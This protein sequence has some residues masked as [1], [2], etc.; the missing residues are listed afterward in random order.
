M[1]MLHVHSLGTQEL[2]AGTSISPAAPIV[3]QER[4]QADHERVE[5]H[6]HLTRLFGSTTLPLALLAQRAGATTADTSSIHHPQASIGFWASLV[7]RECLPCRAT[8]CPIWLDRKI[9]T[10]ESISF[11]GERHLW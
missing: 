5:Q 10:R 7:D 1:G 4:G 8:Q 9:T 3:P 11:P 6:T 2:D